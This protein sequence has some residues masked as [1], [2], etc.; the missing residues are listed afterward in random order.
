MTVPSNHVR[1][2]VP[3][4]ADQGGAAGAPGEGSMPINVKRIT[5]AARITFGQVRN[6]GAVAAVPIVGADINRRYV[7]ILNAG[8]VLV[9]IGDGPTVTIETGFPLGV[10]SAPVGFATTA[11]LYAITP[12]GPVGVVAWV[13]ESDS[14]I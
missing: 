4:Y 3:T 7:Q 2:L 13:S 5:G 12:T 10:G 9:Y 11:Q 6:I 8:A 1:R 14:P